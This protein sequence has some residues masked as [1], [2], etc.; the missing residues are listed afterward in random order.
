[1]ADRF[2]DGLLTPTE[3]AS[4]LRIPHGQGHHRPPGGRGE[5]RGQRVRLR[6]DTGA[7]RR[8]GPDSGAPCRPSPS[9]TAISDVASRKD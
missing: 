5:R 6:H 1:M 2:K 8:L 7:G 9:S 4:H 3:T